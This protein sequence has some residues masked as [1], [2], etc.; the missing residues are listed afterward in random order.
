MFMCVVNLKSVNKLDWKQSFLILVDNKIFRR[1]SL[2]QLELTLKRQNQNATSSRS[3]PSTIL[4]FVNIRSEK[5]W[6]VTM[7]TTTFNLTSTRI[8]LA[9]WCNKMSQPDDRQHSLPEWNNRRYRTSGGRRQRIT[10]RRSFSSGK[11]MT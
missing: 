11:L 2:Y 1:R 7:V 8:K 5:R 4:H 9:K 10:L 6:R 3:T